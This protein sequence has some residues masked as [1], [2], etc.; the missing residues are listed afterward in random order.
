M[1]RLILLFALL[2]VPLAALEAAPVWPPSVSLD[3]GFVYIAPLLIWNIAMWNTIRL[4]RFFEEGAPRGLLAAEAA[5][6]AF[7][8]AYPLFLVAERSSGTYLPGLG[9]YV[10]GT[11]LYAVSWLILA[12]GDENTL[13]SSPLLLLS[14]A[15]TPMLWLAGIAIMTGSPLF[16]LGA[17]V[18]TGLHVAEYVLT[19]R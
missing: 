16:L 13:R 7:T 1:S 4:D 3:N 12:Y 17:G 8:F 9:V 15:Y 2:V 19:R 14:P 10:G 6:R 11:A 5:A 18:F